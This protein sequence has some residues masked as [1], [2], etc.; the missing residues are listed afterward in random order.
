MWN[1]FAL[2]A[3]V[4][5]QFALPAMI[6]A[7]VREICRLQTQQIK[8]VDG[9][10]MLP[11]GAKLFVKRQKVWLYPLFCHCGRTMLPVP[12]V[13]TVDLFSCL[14]QGNRIALAKGFAGRV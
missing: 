13:W 3:N 12:P 4:N 5:F 9:E 2:A 1:I 11:A 6:W 10:V 7:S 8:L 14:G